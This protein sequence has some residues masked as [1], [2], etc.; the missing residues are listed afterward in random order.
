MQKVLIISD[1]HRNIAPAIGVI[2]QIKNYGLGA[3]IHCGD[4]LQDAERLQ[5]LYPEVSVYGVSGNCDSRTCLEDLSKVVTIEGVNFFVTHGHRY[6]IKWGDY[7]ELAID[8]LA[9]DAQVALC[10]HSHS[11][12]LAKIQG[13]L[14]MNPGSISLPRDYPHPSYGIIQVEKGQIQES[15]ILQM[16]E[17]G[18]VRSH[19]I[20]YQ[21]RFK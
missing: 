5:Q 14:V 4:H 13:I 6:L 12:Y 20:A 21:N 19:P 11:A 7:E 9:H 18:Q 15:S 16:I 1:T 17:K 8:A 2:N 3:I 10:G